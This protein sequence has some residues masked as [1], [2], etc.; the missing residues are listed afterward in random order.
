ME[1]QKEDFELKEYSKLTEEKY[2]DKTS[3]K[4]Y[5]RVGIIMRKWKPREIREDEDREMNKQVKFTWN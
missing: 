1:N 5:I 2:N 4:Y 3:P